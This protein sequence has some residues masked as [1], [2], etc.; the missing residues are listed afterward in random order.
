MNM[1]GLKDFYPDEK[2]EV[3]I[4][5]DGKHNDWE[6][7]VL[8]PPIDFDRLE[9]EYWKAVKHIDGR[10]KGRN[11]CGKSFLYSL[12]ET[13]NTKYDYKSFYGDIP[14]CSVKHY[15]FDL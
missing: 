5:F 13:N 7:V 6:G 14:N 1:D 4:D 2:E 15:F 9:A 8:L 12:D 10:E 11:I 3:K